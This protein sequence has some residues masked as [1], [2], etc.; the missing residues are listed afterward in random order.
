MNVIDIKE[1]GLYPSTAGHFKVNDGDKE[2]YYAYMVLGR[3]GSQV[4]VLEGAGNELPIAIQEVVQK[5]KLLRD[6][7]DIACHG[8]FWK[9]LQDAEDDRL[10]KLRAQLGLPAKSKSTSA[11]DSGV[12]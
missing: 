8:A 1:P 10:N 4:V 9:V 12:S 2:V 5:A 11:D 3:T 6:W 7:M